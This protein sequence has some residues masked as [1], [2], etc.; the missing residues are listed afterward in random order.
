MVLTSDCYL[1]GRQVNIDPVLPFSGSDWTPKSGRS[2]ERSALIEATSPEA[3][4]GAGA[5][6]TERNVGGWA[7]ACA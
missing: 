7:G 1:Q 6:F 5:G 4:D 2:L 3:Y